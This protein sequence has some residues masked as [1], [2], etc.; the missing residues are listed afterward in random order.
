MSFFFDKWDICIRF[1]V[2]SLVFRNNPADGLSAVSIATF[3]P[4]DRALSPMEI[5]LARYCIN[6]R[7]V[8]RSHEASP[9]ARKKLHATTTQGG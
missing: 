4:E 3:V 5:R 6:Q 7:N 8:M 1:N 2:L 9:V